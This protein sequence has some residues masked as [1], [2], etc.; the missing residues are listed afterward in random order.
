M[1][2]LLHFPFHRRS[3]ALWLWMVLTLA[4]PGL[5]A[6]TTPAPGYGELG[7]ALPAVGSYQLPPLGLAGDGQVLD[8]Q[9]KVRQ[10]HALMQGG[11]YTLLSFIYSH[12]QDVNGCPLA[13]Y[14]FYRL[15]ALTAPET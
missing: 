11:K 5:A 2:P 6:E 14:V 8:E 10:L 15:K 13:G 3:G 4:I 9:G 7:Y 12:C 1:R